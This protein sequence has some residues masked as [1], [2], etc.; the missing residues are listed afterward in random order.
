MPKIMNLWSVKKTLTSKMSPF[1]INNTPPQTTVLNE[2]GGTDHKIHIWKWLGPVNSAD[3][4]Y[5]I[6]GSS[7]FS[8]EEQI[9]ATKCTDADS[10]QAR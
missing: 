4:K 1:A 2:L 9:L 6:W 5:Q 7:S 10:Q 8:A 3:P